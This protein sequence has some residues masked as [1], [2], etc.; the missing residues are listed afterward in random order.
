MLHQQVL[1]L[2]FKPSK[3]CNLTPVVSSTLMDLQKRHNIVVKPANNVGAIVV[4]DR[5]PHIKEAYKQPDN[6]MNYQ[7]CLIKKKTFLTFCLHQRL[8]A[9]L[10]LCFLLLLLLSIYLLAPDED[11][12]LLK[13]LVF[14]CFF[15][16]CCIGKY[17]SLDLFHYIK[18]STKK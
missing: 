7:K 14:H 1:N 3:R 17:F 6:P 2:Q 13:A 16:F 18:N 11:N 8:L 12:F 4:W 5:N 10:L 9:C 15:V